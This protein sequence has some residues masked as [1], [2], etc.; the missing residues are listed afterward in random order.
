MAT[1]ETHESQDIDDQAKSLTGWEQSY[2]QLGRG[3]FRGSVWQLVMRDGVLLRET[4]NRQHRQQVVPPHGHVVLAMALAVDPGSAF[5]GRPLGRDSL[6]VF[7]SLTQHDVI[8]A[9]EIDLIGV[10]VDSA[11]LEKALAPEKLEWLEH[12]ALEHKVDLP[13][14]TAAAIRLMLLAVCNDVGQG[15]GLERLDALKQERELLSS[16][17]SHAVI[18]A[19]AAEQDGSPSTIPRRAETRLKITK[20]AVEFMRAH[21]EDDIGGPEICSAACASRRTLHYCFEE[22]MHTTPQAYLRALRLNQ[23][24]RA[25]KA[26]ADLPITELAC[27]L[28]FA[29]ASHFTRHYKL[30]FDELPSETLKLYCNGPLA[31]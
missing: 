14:E 16:T 1:L 21:L 31:G 13:P 5:D 28:G 6:M 9:G 8:S 2:E 17:L 3:R 7:N 10:S 25:L 19:M 22:F 27:T 11:L 29:T 12:K 18:L 30:M 24:R 20:R 15:Q 4:N 23:A 26:R